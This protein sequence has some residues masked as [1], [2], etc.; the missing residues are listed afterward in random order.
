MGALGFPDP[1]VWQ[2]YFNDFHE[3]RASDWVTAG[4]VGTGTRVVADERG[5][6]LVLT[7]SAADNDALFNQLSKDGG[8]TVSGVFNL[9]FGKKFFYQ[10]RVKLV[11]GSG[12]PGVTEVD[13]AFGMGIADTGPII[14]TPAGLMFRKVDGQNTITARSSGGT[15]GTQ[16]GEPFAFSANVYNTFSIY[17]N[18]RVSTSPADLVLFFYLNNVRIAAW[19]STGLGTS[20]NTAPSFAV[21]NGQ[22]AASVMS[23]DYIFAA[24]ER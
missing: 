20:N 3:Y 18:G 5:G 15:G 16:A 2:Q 1:T 19:P 24:Q 6:V 17:Y 11:D 4:S 14:T 23:I 7:N 12:T 22:A 9:V 10:T 8:T 13:A 21:Q